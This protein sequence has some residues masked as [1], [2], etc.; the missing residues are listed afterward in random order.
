MIV[1]DAETGRMAPHTKHTENH[2][3][4]PPER[5]DYSTP[6][7]DADLSRG[8]QKAEA[9]SCYRSLRGDETTCTPFCAI[10]VHFSQRYT[11]TPEF[12]AP[13]RTSCQIQKATAPLAGLRPRAIGF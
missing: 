12:G 9:V 11:G 7:M 5:I 4:P 1:D 8:R 3:H 2:D 13:R 6:D 10:G